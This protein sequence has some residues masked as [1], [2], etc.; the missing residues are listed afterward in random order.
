MELP[1][2]NTKLSQG[3]GEKG[4]G[5]LIGFCLLGAGMLLATC[6][7]PNRPGAG[8]PIARLS[9]TPVSTEVQATPTGISSV[10]A[11]P[12]PLP[13]DPIATSPSQPATETPTPTPLVTPDNRYELKVLFD[14]AQHHLDVEEHIT[15]THAAT[16][17]IS[18]LVFSVE[19]NRYPGSFKPGQL[20]WGDGE[21]VKNFTLK[22]NRLEVTLPQPIAYGE[23]IE[24]NITYALELPEI[25]PPADESRPQPYGYTRRQTNLVD[26]YPVLP[27]YMPGEGWLAHDPGYFGEHQVYQSAA[28]QVTIELTGVQ[29]TNQP[30]VIAASAPAEIDG[31]QY[32]YEL[33]Q[34]RNFAWSA[35]NVYTVSTTQVGDISVQSYTFPFSGDGGEAALQ[36]AA[37]AVKL[38]SKLYGPYPGRSLSIIEADFL[39]GMEYEGLFFLSR[40]FYNLYDGTPDGYLTA[41]AVHETAHQWWYGS[42][43]NDQALEPWLDEALCTYSEKLFYENTYP[44]LVDWWWSF[45]VN[46]YQPTGFIN[47]SI[48]D[49]NG[50][51]FYRNAVYLRGAQFREDLRQAV[52]DEAFFAFLKDYAAQNAHGLA[53]A[54]SFFAIL[55]Q[56]SEVDIQPLMQ[57]Y[58]K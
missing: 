54:D 58:F 45:R 8:Q 2:R 10:S 52:G 21:L 12:T 41:I 53:T 38:Y 14:Y 28:Y 31:N 1:A 25:P 23:K 7:L 32:R 11:S 5:I 44:E 42:V 20:N 30:L 36:Y 16:E 6:G 22:N 47:G 50:F 40:G 49:Y 9:E 51:L 3:I 56:H 24:L 15:Y 33:Q 35:S 34:A 46:F 37:E 48:Y 57:E 27:P 4:K 13:A 43:G 18:E 17:P 19:A 39:D 29:N 55:K 26:W